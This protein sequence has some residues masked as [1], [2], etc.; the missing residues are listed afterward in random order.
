MTQVP[1]ITADVRAWE[2]VPVLP[3]VPGL[4][5]QTLAATRS[6]L[7]RCEFDEGC[8]VPTHE[9]PQEQFTIVLEGRLHFTVGAPG[10]E[11]EFDA[12]AGEVVTVAPDVPH[13]ATAVEPTISVDVFTPI[14]EELLPEHA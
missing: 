6:M 14:R 13:T 4:K 3:P 1:E 11:R 10:E 9:H 8:V 5:R 7:M 12:A 2:D